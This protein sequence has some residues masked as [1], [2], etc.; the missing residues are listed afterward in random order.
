MLERLTIAGSPLPGF[1]AGIDP[2][3]VWTA[4]LLAAAAYAVLYARRSGL[5]PRAMYW[6]GVCALAGG[7]WGSHVLA[8]LVHGSDGDASAWL[9]F[10]AGGK[11]YFGGVLGGAAAGAL[12][13]RARR[14]PLPA[15]AD[16]V[17]PAVALGYGLGR[18]G[19]FLN[20]DDYGA[21][22]RL[23]WA[24][25]YPP[26][27]EAFEAHL[28]RGWV[29]PAAQLSLPI[30]PVQLYAAV[31]GIGLCLFLTSRRTNFVGQRFCLFAVLYGAGRFVTEW[32]RGDFREVA[33][34]LSLPQVCSLILLLAGAGVWSALRRDS[35][36]ALRA[37]L[38][39][40]SAGSRSS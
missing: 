8:L 14:L 32:L 27:T 20:G 15:Y 39:L 4:A 5:D 13:L 24:V 35:Q 7:L 28:D 11:S 23:A 2:G 6:G 38:E 33:G 21:V 26:G 17:V 37:G 31:F 29:G 30:H 1:L 3:V 19:C 9:R 25:Q 36:C 12:Y 16:A 40:R 10:W 22:T 34:P 18:V